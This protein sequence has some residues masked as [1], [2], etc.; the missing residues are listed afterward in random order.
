M[1]KAQRDTESSRMV[2]LCKCPVRIRSINCTTHSML[3]TFSCFPKSKRR[4]QLNYMVNLLTSKIYKI[5]KNGNFF[6]FPSPRN[7]ILL[8]NKMIWDERDVNQ[9]PKYKFKL[10]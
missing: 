10:Q 2:K 3:S 1:T 8:I 4:K 7:K 9:H 5:N 6:F